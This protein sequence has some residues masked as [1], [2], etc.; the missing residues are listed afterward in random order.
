M[1]VVVIDFHTH[2]FPPQ[3]RE[4]REEYVRRDP[5]FAEMYGSAR[6]QVATA[7]EL[8]RGM[9]EAGGSV[10][11]AVGLRWVEPVAWVRLA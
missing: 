2:I 8:R 6:A 7:E 11:G 9:A 1:P 10:R 5:T 3:V 4:K